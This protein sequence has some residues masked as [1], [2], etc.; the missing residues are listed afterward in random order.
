VATDNGWWE[1]EQAGAAANVAFFGEAGRSARESSAVREVLHTLGR[2]CEEADVVV[3][4]PDDDVD[5]CAGHA[6]FQVTELLDPGRRRHDEVRD[7]SARL[8]RA[9][10]GDIT[11][12]E[13]ERDEGPAI[14]FDELKARICNAAHIL[15]KTRKTAQRRTLDLLVMVA[16]RGQLE[17]VPDHFE[18]SREVQA[19]GW[20]SV[21][22]LWGAATLVL[23]ARPRAR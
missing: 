14:T 3:P 21:T 6:R 16:L 20:R 12:L 10:P 23:S 15:R 13:T 17:A 18:E 8:Q 4:G 9:T 22:V 7:R 19:M 5:V 1:R 11:A 2:P